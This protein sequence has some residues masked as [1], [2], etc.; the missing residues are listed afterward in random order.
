MKSLIVLLAA[1]LLLPA[2]ISTAADSAADTPEA[3][4]RS[5]ID[6]SQLSLF[7]LMPGLSTMGT[8]IS[9]LGNAT[10]EKVGSGERVFMRLCY[11]SSAKDDFTKLVFEAPANSVEGVPGSAVSSIR[12]YSGDV[13]YDGAGSCVNSALVSRDTVTESGVG[14]AMSEAEFIE[15]IGGSPTERWSGFVG[16]EYHAAERLSKAEVERLKAHWPFVLKYPYLDIH[17]S[18]EARFYKGSLKRLD[19]SRIVAKP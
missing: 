10:P 1:L 6:S 8:V 9:V 11:V 17:S 14:L 12:L 15:R 4:I 2:S 3:M 16:F 7:G 19:L 18:V 5:D 13:A